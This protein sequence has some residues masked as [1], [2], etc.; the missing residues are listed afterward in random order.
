[1]V[2]FGYL[3]RRSPRFKPAPPFL[4]VPTLGRARKG[5]RSKRELGRMAPERETGPDLPGPTP[6]RRTGAFSGQVA[7]GRRFVGLLRAPGGA[8]PALGR[9]EAAR[10]TCPD[11]SGRPGASWGAGGDVLP[12]R[13]QGRRKTWKG[14]RERWPHGDAHGFIL[15]RHPLATI[16]A[17]PTRPRVGESRPRAPRRGTIAPTRHQPRPLA[18]CRACRPEGGRVAWVGYRVTRTGSRAR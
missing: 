6:A 5:A 13:T 7:S 3:A 15:A 18:S 4:G 17:L 1:M 10:T 16:G 12:S 8:F 14:L 9:P 11:A 2:T